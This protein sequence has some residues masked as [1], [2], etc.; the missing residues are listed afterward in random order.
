MIQSEQQLTHEEH[1]ALA[2]FTVSVPRRVRRKVYQRLELRGCGIAFL[3]VILAID[4]LA[5]FVPALRV[6][7]AIA[8]GVFF[9]LIGLLVMTALPRGLWEDFRHRHLV[10]KGVVVIGRV[11]KREIKV[12]IGSQGPV[13]WTDYALTYSFQ[14]ASGE[15]I[16]ATRTSSSLDKFREGGPIL[17]IY[18]PQNPRKH[19]PFLLLAYEPIA[20]EIC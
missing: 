9:G 1:E 8:V 6:N 16:V 17:I 7:I 4:G 20:P 5:F 18:L 19:E 15:L 12:D 14:P 13:G 10:R 11:S 3:A 2:G